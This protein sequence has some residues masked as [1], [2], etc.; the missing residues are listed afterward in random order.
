[1]RVVSPTGSISTF[2]TGGGPWAV[3][4][5]ATNNVYIAEYNG[6]RIR[7]I[8]TV[9]NANT[10]VAETGAAGFSGD[11]GLATAAALNEPRGMVIDSAG[12]LLFVDRANHRVRKV[13]PAGIISTI[14][15]TGARTFTVDGGPASAATLAWPQNLALRPDGTIL[16][17]EYDS[18]RIRS[19]SPAGIISTFAGG[20]GSPALGDGGAASAACLLGPED[21]AVDAAGNV[22]LAENDSSR[23]RKVST[24]GI[25]TTIAGTGTAGFSGSKA[26]RSNQTPQPPGT[27]FSWRRSP[28]RHPPRTPPASWPISPPVSRR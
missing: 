28:S 27:V 5:D 16:I 13:T 6:H 19:I 22:Y 1:M 18:N 10:L 4:V 8:N 24:D 11:G 9:T 2:Y 7:R 26:P 25:I 15:G 17:A 23:I 12:N 14:A 21:V 3:M 20:G